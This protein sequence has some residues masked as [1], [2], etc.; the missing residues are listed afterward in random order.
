MRLL[1]VA[2]AGACGVALAGACGGDDSSG[3]SG[4]AKPDAS[5]GGVGGT[6]GGSG[7]T[8]GDATF[9][10]AP[11]HTLTLEF[12]RVKPGNDFVAI[13]TALE[14]GVTKPGLS[15]EIQSTRGSVGSVSDLGDGTYRATITND[16]LGTGEY[17]VTADAGTWAAPVNRTAV[18]LKEVGSR[19]GQ[20]QAFAGLVN[21]PGWEDSLAIAPDGE[22]IILEYLPVSI[23]CILAHFDEPTHPSCAK[24]IG[25]WQAP[26]RP[27]M[28]GAS[29]IAADG[30]IHHGCPSLGLDPAPFAVPPQSLFGFRRQVDGS[31]AEP[32]AISIDGVDGCVSAFGP[33]MLAPSGGKVPLVFA[34][35][36][37]LDGDPPAGSQA[38]VFF[39]ELELGKPSA[40]GTYATS[41]LTMNAT[42]L[43]FPTPGQ[44][45]NPH[46]FASS[47]TT[48][49]WVDDETLAEKDLSVYELQGAFPAGP[50]SGP[51]KL[52]SPF[53]DAG[54]DDIQPFYDG[55]EAIWTRD[56]SIVSSAHTAGAVTAAASWGAV[57]T[58]LS[59]DPIS[60]A[61]ET[62]VGVG[63]PTKATRG[64]RQV[65]AFVYVRHAP[66]GDIDIN[67]GFVEEQP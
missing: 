57:S 44:Q 47:G 34:F 9:D 11:A 25:P 3:G 49:I 65:L 40:L 53:G 7:G 27:G 17:A 63:E 59:G 26:E 33:S 64:G 54:K 62:V 38:D 39:T 2:C 35:D 61:T 30:S 58:E 50:W 8:A 45:G 29:R 16:A 12:E 31:F 60:S 1:A 19:W 5:T 67:A 46:Y 37:P 18:V 21:T 13:V 22:W 23:T 24:A 28:P 43:G 36:S 51:T 14:G 66:S 55:S 15:V 6:S 10:P 52:P 56:L 48:Q 42:L 41:Q 20:P 32:F 4:G